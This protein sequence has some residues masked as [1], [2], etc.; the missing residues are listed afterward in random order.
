MLRTEERNPRT[1]NIDRCST[2]EMMEMIQRENEEAARAVREAIEDISCACDAIAERMREGGRLFYIGAG[3]SGR[4]GVL[5]AAECPPTYGISPDTVIGIIAGG[6]Q[7]M[8]RASENREDIGAAGVRDLAAYQPTEKDSV[9]GI[10]AAGGA[11]YV[12]EALQ[13]ANTLGCLT[14]AMTNNHGTPLEKVANM[15]IVTDT[16]PEVVTGST[17]MKAGSAQK[18]VLR[19]YLGCRRTGKG[20]CTED[21]RGRC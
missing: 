19:K 16:G 20:V 9:V 18:M 3:T 7:C 14:I 6:E 8:F 21:R 13:Y 11:S 10:S 12:I 1:M 4:L 5:D 2:L 17:R 15:A